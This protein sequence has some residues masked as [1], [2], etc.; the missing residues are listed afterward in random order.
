VQIVR[1]SLLAF[2]AVLMLLISATQAQTT[3][4]TVNGLVVDNSGA[5]I[6]G[7]SVQAINEGTNVAF[8]TTTN[9]GGVYA[10][11]NLPPGR[12]RIQVE[13]TGFKI[14]VKPDIILNVQDA[15]AV[16]FTLQVGATSEVV[17]VQGG[18][19]LVNA[20]SSA[21]STVIDRNFAENLPLN[22]RSFQSLIQLTPGVVIAPS[23]TLDPGQFSINGQR[24]DA[25]YWTV[26]GV[27]A[28]VGVAALG[29]GGISG[30]LGAFGAQ[31]GTNSLVSVDAMQE[32]RLQTSTY[33]AE[34]G[35]QPGGQISIVTRSG[36]NRFSGTAFEYLRNDALDA[37]NWFN[38]YVTPAIPKPAERQN[39]F[40]G[41]FSGPIVKDRT[42]FFFSYEGNRL[43]LPRTLLTTVLCDSTCNSP[44]GSG[45]LRTAAPA[46]IQPFLNAYP[47]PNG[48]EIFSPCDPS[49]DPNCPA[50]GE[51]PTGTAPLNASYSDASS[52]D[53]VSLRIDHRVNDR[54]MLFGR[55]DY[56]PSNLSQRGTFGNSPNSISNND[57]KIQ[58]GT[59]GAT[60]TI[61]PRMGNDFRFN[62][63]RDH[64]SSQITMDNFHGAVP[65]ASLPLPPGF[66]A[67]N[68]QFFFDI[69]PL[70]L[71]GVGLG[72]EAGKTQELL[73]R[74]INFVDGFYVQHGS[75]SLKFGIDYRRLS[76]IYS[77]QSYFQET[78]FNT[79]AS[80]ENAT[81][82]FAFIT[83]HQGAT[84]LFKNLGSYAQDTWRVTPRLTLTYGLR[85]DIDFAPSSLKG[86]SL[87]AF[88]GYNLLDV[89][90]LGLAPQGTPPYNT[91]Y[92]DFAPRVGLAYE[93]R[94]N[95]QWG[96]VLRGGYGLFYDM[97]SSQVGNI[98]F[99]SSY[100]F[101]AFNFG[102]GVPFPLDTTTIAAPP[103][104]TNSSIVAS[105]SNP[106]LKLPYTEEWNVAIEQALGNQQSFSATYAGAVGRRLLQ[107]SAGFPPALPPSFTSVGLLDNTATSDYHALQLQFRRQ[108]SHGLQ[109]LASYSW[110]HS[111]DTAS[112]A[113]VGNPANVLAGTSGDRAS[114]D[115]DIRHSFSTALT[116]QIPAPSNNRLVQ[117]VL[118]GWSLEN[119]FQA[120]TAPPV[121]VIDQNF[122]VLKNLYVTSIRPDVVPGEPLYLYGSQFPGGKAFNPAAFQSV[123]T[124][125]DPIFGV[126]PARQGDLPRNGLSAFGAWQ[127]DYAVHREFPIRESVR[128]DFRAEMFNV[129]NHPNF[130]P[131]VPDISPFSTG[132]GKSNQLLADSFDGGFLNGGSNQGG[133]SFS[134]IY[135]FGGPR[136][137]QFAMKLKF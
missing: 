128:L 27:S 3:N 124:I 41:T 120:R 47:L 121:N 125:P 1:S 83:Q 45:N 132:F 13:K 61:S 137:I 7:A 97:A 133:G 112:A 5:V 79:I 58:T 110:A 25:N 99:R 63:S 19:S 98:I 11:P 90:K 57:F 92:G 49:T 50:S 114:S 77:P 37:D 100:P 131:P 34:F 30:S 84:L 107:S 136:T 134:P 103:P 56:S 85:W 117:A 2:S 36:S 76:P 9:S 105:G 62:Y 10:L 135:Q 123:P 4:A 46:A 129:L 35:R 75:H 106:H 95:P 119:I 28:N 78:N 60:W 18:A 6:I 87:L 101:E 94:Q 127:W 91:T 66:T 104:F 51:A 122:L 24:T 22:G 42:F 102:F 52:L 64:T 38:T 115:F 59:V 14:L 29:R 111:I 12:Y 33:A 40:G 53:A 93:L 16:N 54:L 71:G 81:A 31:G 80:V 86:P 73:Q 82:D 23:S 88:T 43:R 72:L 108:L 109:A 55:Y 69:L 70:G 44:G 118:R 130:G 48:P 32:F 116:Y 67:E 8:R 65:L 96:T 113:S 20:E 74:Q 89:S 17:T 15:R 68:S 26:D 126:V 21:V 39:N